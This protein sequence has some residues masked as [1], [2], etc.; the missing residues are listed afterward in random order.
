[1]TAPLRVRTWRFT[2]GQP[3]AISAASACRTRAVPM[4]RPWTRGLTATRYS[5]PRC[6][7][8]PASAVP[9]TAPSSSATKNSSGWTALFSA[10]MRGAS[11]CGRSLAKTSP[12]SAVTAAESASRNV[13]MS[14][15]QL[16]SQPG[17]ARVP[18]GN[19]LVHPR[20]AQ[21]LLL[22]ERRAQDLQADRQTV[23]PEASLD[24][25]P[26]DAR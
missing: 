4:P 13:R 23:L 1:M 9:T 22:L 8:Y 6:P 20:D 7:S 24:A 21:E 5:Q 10:K 2:F 19:L 16:R 15:R 3:R 14:I 26:R 18:V 17:A 25:D 12:H 11:L